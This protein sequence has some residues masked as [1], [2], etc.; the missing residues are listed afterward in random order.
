MRYEE[1]TMEKLLAPADRVL[2]EIGR[3]V[4]LRPR[5]SGFLLIVAIFMSILSNNPFGATHEADA[6]SKLTIP[7]TT[8]PVVSSIA[9]TV[10]SVPTLTD[11]AA[12]STKAAK[13]AAKTKT[14]AAAKT[15]TNLTDDD[16]KVTKVR[17]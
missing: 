1:I 4:L 12:A 8:I 5:I 6:L 10:D 17:S 11:S 7:L 13:T 9:S 15:S 16:W 2:S 14:A 3:F